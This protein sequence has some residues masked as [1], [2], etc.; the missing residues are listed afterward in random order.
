MAGDEV[1][2]EGL[3]KYVVSIHGRDYMTVSGRIKEAQSEGELNCFT[4][5]LKD[6][7][8][9][10][11]KAIVQTARGASVGHAAAYGVTPIDKQNPY[12]NAETSAVG[13]ALGFLGYGLIA[14]GGVASAEEMQGVVE[15]E[16]KPVREKT[17]GG[18][19]IKQYNF[20][21]DLFKANHFDADAVENYLVDSWG[22][23]I[24]KGLKTPLWKL[25][26]FDMMS[27]II[28]DLLERRKEIES[29]RSKTREVEKQVSESFEGEIEGIDDLPF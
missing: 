20:A 15:P 28:E 9:I 6:D 24:K 19:T 3:E 1:E 12:E 21:V 7:E 22:Y 16:D 29:Q 18:A 17:P 11:V 4:E 10:I 27:K 23:E 5:I 26:D 13:R 8:V 2:V 14:E 25:V